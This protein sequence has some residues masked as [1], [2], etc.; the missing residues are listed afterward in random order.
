MSF[1]HIGL[2]YQESNRTKKDKDKITP[3]PSK[4]FTFLPSPSLFTFEPRPPATIPLIEECLEELRVYYPPLSGS[5]GPDTDLRTVKKGD[6]FTLHCPLED[7]GYPQVFSSKNPGY[8]QEFSR[9]GSGLSAGIFQKESG[10]SAGIFKEKIWPLHRYFEWISA[11][12]RYFPGKDPAYPQVFS[13][14]RSGLSAGIFQERIRAIRRY[15]PGED[16][17]YRKVFSRKKPGYPQVFP[18]ED[19]TIRR[20]FLGEDQGYPQVFS[21]RDPGYR[22]YFPWEDSGY[23]QIFFRKASGLPTDIF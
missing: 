13:K 9:R 22:R 1:A 21:R 6:N 4:N 10:H 3:K 19:P 2:V 12:H 7:P 23:P 16:P 5:A 18:G 8:P 17:G 15:F 14:R 20:Y 11:T